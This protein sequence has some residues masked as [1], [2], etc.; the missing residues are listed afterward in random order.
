MF[1]YFFIDV[2]HSNAGTLALGDNARYNV[3]IFKNHP[4]RSLLLT[5]CLLIS[6][7]LPAQTHWEGRKHTYP[8][9]AA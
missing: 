7:T 8:L 1:Y 9:A 5:K 4:K 3:Q 2:F 6:V